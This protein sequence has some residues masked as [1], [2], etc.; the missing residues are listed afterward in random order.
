[1]GGE[2]V[3]VIQNDF[4]ES[5][6]L[7]REHLKNRNAVLHVLHAY[8]MLES[9]Q[10]PPLHSY[11]AFIVGPTPISAND[12]MNYGY[13]AKEWEYLTRVIESGKPC[14]GIC[15]GGQMLARIMGA[16]VVRSP[17][18]EVGGYFVEL[19]DDGVADPIFQG[20]PQMF[21]VFHWH[22]DMFQIPEGGKKLAVGAVC[23]IQSFGVGNV[24]GVIFHLEITCDEATRWAEAYPEELIAVGK[25]R[26]TVIEE[27]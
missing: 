27:C 24:R 9:D 17:R 3:L 6:G 2:R 25:T 13:L 26:E 19:T 16:K 22:T 18:K 7:Y 15:C 20:F 23:P 8:R 5:L 14:L 21:P 4:T 11:D 12:V 10:F 1:M